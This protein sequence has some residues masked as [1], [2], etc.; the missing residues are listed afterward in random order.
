MK[1]TTLTC[2]VFSVIGFIASIVNLFINGNDEIKNSYP[3]F[4]L[5]G[6]TLFVMIF[7]I[8]F[9]KW[10][11]DKDENDLTLKERSERLNSRVTFLEKTIEELK[12]EIER[13]KIKN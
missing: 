3:H 7:F 4:I 2:V 11:L 9:Y 8:V 5:F 1:K 13:L 10:V 12:E 6:L